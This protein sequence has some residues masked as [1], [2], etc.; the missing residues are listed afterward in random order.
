MGGSALSFETRRVCRDEYFVLL[1]EIK[2]K[3]TDIGEEK[4]TDILAYHTKPSFGDIDILIC[5]DRPNRREWIRSTFG[6]NEIHQNSDVF[7]FDYKNVQVDFIFCKEDNFQSSYWYFAWNDIGNIYSRILHRFGLRNGHD[8]L[9]LVVRDDT[10][11]IGEILLTKNVDEILTFA[12]YDP[13]SYK[14][15]FDTKE[16]IFKY[17]V[18][19]PYYNYEIFDLENRNYRA[20]TRDRK[21]PMYTEFLEWAKDNAKH[22]YEW[23]LNKADYIPHILYE[24]DKLDVYTDML[25]EHFSN[26]D[27]KKKFNGEVVSLVTGLQGK[28]LGQMMILLKADPFFEKHV[29]SYM[30][31]ET[32]ESQI[33][34]RFELLKETLS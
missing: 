3:L 25:R 24:F 5:S 31:Q 28:Q 30:N 22:G 9:T 7:S 16:E 12:G 1:G 33:K 18:S 23:S 32:I 19:S 8:G 11:V 15:G 21:R 2:Q 26:L 29:L 17:V 20:R 4:F 6:P 13:V 10:R 27:F 14:K 34:D